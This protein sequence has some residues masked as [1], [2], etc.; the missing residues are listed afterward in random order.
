MTRLLVA[1]VVV[2]VAALVI[3]LAI[4]LGARA[5][6]TPVNAATTNDTTSTTRWVETMPTLPSGFD[7]LK[8]TPTTRQATVKARHAGNPAQIIDGHPC[9]GDLPPCS[10]M[11]LESGGDP[12]AYNPTGCGGRGCRGKW[13]CDPRTCSG[14]GTE[15]EQD[16]EARAL[17]DDGAGCAHWDACPA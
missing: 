12:N 10:V 6:H 9:G 17:W 14:T 8:L 4:T 3:T 2:A 1:V 16:D 5:T 7:P 13:Q 11:L 15:A